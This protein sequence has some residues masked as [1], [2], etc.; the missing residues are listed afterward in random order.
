MDDEL[1]TQRADPRFDSGFKEIEIVAYIGEFRIVGVAHF[2]VGA[3]ASSRRASDYIR[4]F[5]DARLTLSRVR[6][7]NKTTKEL[8][9]TAP[10]VL[11]NMD[12]VDFL[13]GRDQE[14][15]APAVEAAAEAAASE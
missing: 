3:R 15:E 7:Y 4:S 13:Y 10:F 5:N 12:K 14:G 2:G 9:D 1:G 11:V 8:I 6:I